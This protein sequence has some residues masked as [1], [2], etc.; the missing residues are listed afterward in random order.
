MTAKKTSKAKKPSKSKKRQKKGDKDLAKQSPSSTE[1]AKKIKKNEAERLRKHIQTILRSI[2]HAPGV[3][4]MID[5]D[6]EVI[7]VGKAKDL[8]KRV[9]S[10]FNKNKHEPKTKIMVAK[11]RDIQT[12][13]VSTE[14]EAL[15]V[16]TN[17]I[18][19]F[20]P[21]YNVLMRD[22]KNVSYL[23]ITKADD[24]PRIEAVRKVGNDRD[25]SRYFGPYLNASIPQNSL[26]YI[27]KLFPFRSC[28]GEI[29]VIG[30]GRK[31]GQKVEVE[32]HN[33]GVPRIP[34]LLYHM[35]RC[36]A[37]CIGKV[38]I[39]EY[40]EII[41][42]V[43]GVLEGKTDELINDLKVQMEKA[44][45]AKDFEKAAK[46]RDRALVLEKL[47]ANQKQS[48]AG[49]SKTN[50][51]IVNFAIE[52][53]AAAC[54]LLRIRGGR[55]IDSQQ[56]SFRVNPDI[57]DPNEV[58]DAI[59]TQYYTDAFD[60]PNEIIVPIKTDST[61]ALEALLAD[62][63]GKTVKLRAPVRGDAKKLLQLARHNAAHHLE[64]VR[65]K[66]MS[67]EKKTAT[68]IKELSEN[69]GVPDL[70]RIECYDISHIQGTSKVGSMIVF[71]DGTPAKSQ[72]RRFQIKS[73]QEGVS[74]DFASLA[75]VLKRRLTYLKEEQERIKQLEKQDIDQRPDD[76]KGAEEKKKGKG[77]KKESA[78]KSGDITTKP[79]KP[80]DSFNALPSL[81]LIDGGK[82]QL[83]AV[84]QIIKELKLESIPI[85][86]LAK[87]EEELFLP[88]RKDAL[89][90]DPYSEALYL[91]QR[92]R[93]EAHRFAISYHRN[94]R[95]KK[96]V[97][98]RLDQIP[99]LGPAAKKK[100]LTK[101]GSV[102]GVRDA[103]EEELAA[104]VPAGLA[105]RIKD[106]L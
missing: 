80:D 95:S 101:F 3:Y 12:I 105:A 98:S 102:K 55:L 33:L 77:K 35:K 4:K 91:V 22:D 84:R 57:S 26:E 1:I 62:R 49:V 23:K 106:L 27:K 24:Y 15:L 63:L 54:V 73:L 64:E 14:V 79:K 93:D 8:K 39:E 82:G 30:P 51:D 74:D 90:L 58:L 19:E 71:I 47:Q 69:M 45:Q 50:Q 78:K 36:V 41:D 7:Y 68:A 42:Q 86:A 31:D 81:I 16:E 18:K 88:D 13:T 103:S 28:R 72:Y 76:E 83:S 104:I 21:R 20:R 40:R 46:L 96:M 48:V 38:T 60:I 59:L 10:Y 34:C 99:G 9:S 92:I 87:R 75:E 6:G 66:W 61:Q 44:A 67:E 37:P 65:L 85:A 52:S 89:R 53:G 2:S 11:I 97:K 70:N 29:N 94:V 5:K 17:L 32:N 43:E 56:S 25:T 100:L